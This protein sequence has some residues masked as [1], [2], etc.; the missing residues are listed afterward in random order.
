LYL[1]RH[2]K[3][4]QPPGGVGDHARPLTP[5]GIAAASRIGARLKSLG[6][7]LG[8]VLCSTAR[9]TVETYENAAR[10][11]PGLEASLDDRIYDAN[12]KELLGLVRAIDDGDPTATVVGHNPAMGELAVALAGAGELQQLAAM[13]EG[14]APGSVARIDFDAERWSDVAPGTGTLAMF[15]TP[16]DAGTV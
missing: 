12:A 13:A 14:F 10:S 11:Y 1:F 4:S 2:A 6:A 3:A 15:L 9:R 7:A 8:H 5:D 16:Q